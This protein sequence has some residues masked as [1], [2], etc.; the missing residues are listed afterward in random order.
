MNR[1]REGDKDK[2][3]KAQ[4]IAPSPMVDRLWR[5]LISNFKAYDDFCTKI[6]QKFYHRKTDKIAVF[7]NYKATVE[8]YSHYFGVPDVMTWPPYSS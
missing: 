3:P 1:E 2:G 4:D 6:F 8:L 5:L 7:D